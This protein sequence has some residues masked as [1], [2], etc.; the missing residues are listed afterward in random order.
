MK[1]LILLFLL[2]AVISVNAQTILYVKSADNTLYLD[3]TVAA[4]EGLYS[5]GRLYNVNPK[6]IAGYNKIDLNKGLSIGEV[7]RIPLSDTN[8]TNKNTKGAPIYYTVQANEGL[9]KISNVNRKVPLASLRKWNAL[10]GDN[11]PA[12]SAII[13]GYL[14]SKEAAAFGSLKPGEAGKVEEKKEAVAVVTKPVA[15]KEVK[16]V[17]EKEVKPVV[18]AEKVV[19]EEKPKNVVPKAQEEITAMAG[20]AGYFKPYFD[21][22]LKNTP[23]SHNTTVSSGIF[24]TVSGWQDAKFYMLIDGVAAGNIIRV[25]NPDNNKII[26]AKVLGEMNGIRQNQ[27]LGTRIS[28]AAASALGIRD[29]EKFTL[30]LN[31]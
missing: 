18:K 22:Q 23:A 26:Y 29:T 3:H 28:S 12:G 31:Y 6:H 19:I 2:F 7:V 8:F 24:K 27:G 14:V 5:I 17:A 4:K 11:V 30:Q 15:E 25:I 10:T 1:K 16:Q 13:I 20:S 9:Q 21:Q